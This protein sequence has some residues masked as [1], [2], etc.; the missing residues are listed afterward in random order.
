MGRVVA[1]A[2]ARFLL[3][4]LGVRVTGWRGAGVEVRPGGRPGPGL[5]GL[6]DLAG[7]PSSG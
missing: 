2:A 5:K 1:L 6:R 7:V 4:G 3:C